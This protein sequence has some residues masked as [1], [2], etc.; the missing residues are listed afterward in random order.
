[1][2][3]AL[4]DLFGQ[5]LEWTQQAW[6]YESVTLG[7]RRGPRHNYIAPLKGMPLLCLGVE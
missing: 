5:R 6:N 4:N 2:A 7:D 1:M 3:G